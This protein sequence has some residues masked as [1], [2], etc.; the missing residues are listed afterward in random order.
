MRLIIRLIAGLS[1]AVMLA[2][3]PSE[4]QARVMMSGMI[5][6]STGF[7]FDIVETASFTI[8]DWISNRNVW[9]LTI[10]NAPTDT[11]SITS[12]EIYVNISSTRYPNI[13]GTNG[14]PA[15]IYVIGP[16]AQYFR[17]QPLLPNEKLVVDN[18]VI[19]SGSSYMTGKWSNAF[20][21]EVLR[22][23]FLPEDSYTMEFSLHGHYS[24]GK[25]FDGDVNPITATIEIRNPGPPELIAPINMAEDA[26][27]IP[28][29]SWQNPQISNLS[30]LNK[31]IR[32]NYT[33]TLWKMFSENGAS[34][35]SE[36]AIRRL[37]IWKRTDLT[38]PSIDFD[39]GSSR[40]ELISGRRYCWQVQAFD[41]TGRPISS[42]ND[43]KS[44]VWQFTVR[45]V[46]SNINQPILFNPLE[47]S[48]TPAQ[49]GGSTVL[50]T[51]SV[52][53]N[54]DFKRAYISRGQAQ[55]RFTYPPDAPALTP[56]K[57]AYIRIQVTD[58]YDLPIGIPTQETVT[59]PLSELVLISPED[60]YASPTL[61]PNFRWRGEET[62]FVVNIF[63]EGTRWSY[64]SPKIQE[65]NW[66]YEGEEL[67]PGQTYSWKVIPVDPQGNPLGPGSDTRT[68]TVPGEGQICLVSPVSEKIS[69]IF[70]TFTWKPLSE[71]GEGVTYIISI[72]SETGTV[73]HTA[74]VTGASYEYPRTGTMLSYSTK[75][76]WDVRAQQNNADVGTKSLQASFIT[77][78]VQSAGGEVSLEDIT[79]A[80]KQLASDFPAIAE[81]KNKVVTAIKDK[82]GTITPSQLLEMLGTFKINSV[83][84][85]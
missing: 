15:K 81:L 51:V 54:P 43:G 63:Q 83:T 37:P 46:P 72:Y 25:T 41:G 12:A 80:I 34:L 36:E 73:V 21:D 78:F 7:S 14:Q 47:F 19:A 20:K 48:W 24:N 38:T 4:A 11:L 32:V 55:T 53:D 79:E 66:T 2:G 22:I 6:P 67:K 31:T 68:F 77:P 65:T 61:T 1:L 62:N 75:Y 69:T 8:D 64:T 16:T 13:V 27:T 40:E 58:E 52:A 70:P 50:Y 85:K 26:V 9:W 39:P 18:T 49:A 29:F 84:V 74:N 76:L 42:T 33:L 45:F 10:D 3:I 17:N 59:I 30:Q 60:N 82:N 57:T 44:D 5:N 23:G 71:K 28:R 56:G 35:S